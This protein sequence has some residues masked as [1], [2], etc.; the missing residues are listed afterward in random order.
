MTIIFNSAEIMMYEEAI[1]SNLKTVFREWCW[2]KMEVNKSGSKNNKIKNKRRLTEFEIKVLERE[3][4][5]ETKILKNMR[6]W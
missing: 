4:E 2:N 1:R 3:V 6:E 5:K